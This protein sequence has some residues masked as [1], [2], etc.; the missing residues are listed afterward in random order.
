MRRS[1]LILACYAVFSVGGVAAHAG[2]VSLIVSTED[3][4]A[5]T[6]PVQWAMGQL[7]EALQAGG[8][9]SHVRSQILDASPDDRCVV[10][11]GRSSNLAG[12]LLKPQGI[13]VPDTPEALGL[14][15]GTLDGRPVLLAC[16]SDTRG[17]VYAL[18]ELADRIQCG[19][20]PSDALQAP[21]PIIE[22]PA[23]KTRSIYRTFTS[24]VEDK[25]WYNDREFWRSYLTEL[26][27]QRINR[28]SLA[29]GMGYN[30]P[31]GCIDS[32]FFFPYPFLLDVPGYDVRAVGLPDEER[33]HNLE[34][35]KFISDEAAA[36]GMEFQLALWSHGYDFPENVNYPIQGLT[37]KNHAAYCRDA[38]AMLLKACPSI[39]GTTLRVHGE[40]GIPEGKQGFWEVAVP[41]I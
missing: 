28:F 36:R 25:S 41:G 19:M 26:A 1:T 8:V 18:L 35:L 31:K 33:D 38:L 32:Y 16:G 12:K 29:L 4:T 34:M 6:K 10:V 15:E 9:D 7:K 2:G 21:N 39:T 13:M 11:A 23:M 40:S 22:K 20:A 3:T 14:V 30:N 5:N 27:K 24:E 37:E 17:L